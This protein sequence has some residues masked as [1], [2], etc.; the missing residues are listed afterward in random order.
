MSRTVPQSTNARHP[1]AKGFSA[2]SEGLLVTHLLIVAD[3][4]RSREFYRSVLGAEVVRERDPV[5]LR[6]ANSWII[7]NTGGARPMTSP[8]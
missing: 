3:P 8:M 2:P 6:F 1:H 5:A 7:L 4:D